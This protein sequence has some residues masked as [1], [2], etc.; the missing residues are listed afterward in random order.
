MSGT[1][2]GIACFGPIDPDPHSPTWGFITST[3]KLEW[4][5]FDF[6]GTMHNAIDVPICFDT[7]VNAAALGEVFRQSQRIGDSAFAFLVG[8]IDVFQAEFFAVCEQ[9]KEIA[10][11]SAAGYDQQISNPSIH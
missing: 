9:A 4:Q 3:P 8:V 10:G 11:V 5:N 6:A 1:P 2:G 7:V